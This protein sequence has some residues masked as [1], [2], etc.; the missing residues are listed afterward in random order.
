MKLIY[1]RAG[2]SARML[3][4]LDVPALRPADGMARKTELKLPRVAESEMSRHYA[5]LG[6]AAF[7]VCDG[8]YP[9]GSCTMKY[10]PKVNEAMAAL[11]GFTDAHPTQDAPGCAHAL[12]LAR[13]REIGFIFQSSQ[14]LSRLDAQKNVE[15]PLI[16]AGVRPSERARRAREMLDRVGLSDRMHHFPSQ[17]SG[18]QQQRVAIARALVTDPRI[19]LAD[20]PTGALDQATGK[21][22]MALFRALNDEGRTILMITHDLSIA[23]C[24]RR[25]VHIVD[26]ELTEGGDAR[27]VQSEAAS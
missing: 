11:P 8:F 15:L 22:V 20:E 4:P 14:L 6:R 25:V 12:A 17:L 19:L 18:G 26:G 2:E 27:N 9:L 10:N 13:S 5:K 3:E 21:Q 24:A 16:Y 1:E 7:G 23:R